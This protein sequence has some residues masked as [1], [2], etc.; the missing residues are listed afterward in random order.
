MY[1]SNFYLS[2]KNFST[3]ASWGG[4]GGGPGSFC[5]P[6]IF[7]WACAF[8]MWATQPLEQGITLMLWVGEL[9]RQNAKDTNT[10]KMF[11]YSFKTEDVLKAFLVHVRSLWSFYGSQALGL[12]IWHL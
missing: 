1:E 8:V 5:H 11:K 7:W 4:G 10:V 6:E 12:Y 9:L 3:W 2:L